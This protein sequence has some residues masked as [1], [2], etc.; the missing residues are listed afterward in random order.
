MIWLISSLAELGSSSQVFWLRFY[1]RTHCLYQFIYLF[2]TTFQI[3]KVPLSALQR[4]IIR[5]LD[6]IY[7][8]DPLTL[9]VFGVYCL[10]KHFLKL[11]FDKKNFMTNTAFP[12]ISS[13]I[14]FYNNL[15]RWLNN[16]PH[17]PHNNLLYPILESIEGTV[18]PMSSCEVV[19]YGVT[20]P[21]TGS[22]TGPPDSPLL[23]L[24]TFPLVCAYSFLPGP[25]QTISLTLTRGGHET[26]SVAVPGSKVYCRS[27]CGPSGCQC[28][29]KYTRMEEIDHLL[30]VAGTTPVS[31]LCGYFPVSNFTPVRI[32]LL[33]TS[34][35]PVWQ[36]SNLNN[37]VPVWI[38]LMCGFLE[39]G[40]RHRPRKHTLCVEK[41]EIDKESIWGTHLCMCSFT[42]W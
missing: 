40:L 34:L 10:L 12:C 36:S 33:P 6:W 9:C 26:S 27:F 23:R 7:S 17:T 32:L 39:K 2:M 19:Y 21:P 25:N 35:S 28:E 11:N 20:S 3:F 13:W 24:S 31:C 29:S 5:S 14:L 18:K 37:N 38:D 15:K 41:V 4:E 16:T 42:C 1:T 30:I 8:S 22:I